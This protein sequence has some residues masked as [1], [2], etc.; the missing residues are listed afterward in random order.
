MEQLSERQIRMALSA[1]VEPGDIGIGKLLLNHSA[2]ELF[3]Q[4][5]LPAKVL[6]EITIEK[7]HSLEE[8]TKQS[9]ARYL[10]PTDEQWPTGFNFLGPLSPAGIWVRGSGVP[11]AH[12]VSIVGA[13][14][15]T[16]YGENMASQI[17]ADL[18]A[19]RFTVISGGAFGIDAAAHKGAM[20][21]GGCTVAVLAGGV[22]VPYPKGNFDMFERIMETGWL[23]SEVPPGSIPLKHRF[24]I[25][26]R[27]IAAWSVGTVVVEARIRSGAISTASHAN[28]LGLEVMAVPGQVTSPSSSGCHQLIRDG[29]TLVTSAAEVI[30][31]ISPVYV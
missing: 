26:N 24:L 6:S 16:S 31:Q 23:V 21:A 18:V 28:N 11:T 2:V 20:W 15:C 10:I 4:R 27:L 5:L 17:A 3:R 30:Q 13:R 1:A 9:N 25:R 8:A 22:D 19:S 7:I 14:S 29:A 12:T